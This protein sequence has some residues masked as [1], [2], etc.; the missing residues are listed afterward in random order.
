MSKYIFT[1]NPVSTLAAGVNNTDTSLFLQTGEGSLFALPTGD[2]IQA[3]TLTDNAGN[4]E[5]CHVTGRATD[6]L[7]VIRG[8][9]GTAALPWL[10]GDSVSGRNTAGALN[11]TVQNDGSQDLKT[12][13]N[14]DLVDG[15]EPSNASGGISINNTILNADLNADQIDDLEGEELMLKA[16]N[17][18]DVDDLGAAKQNLGIGKHPWW[19]QFL[20]DGSDGAVIHAVNTSLPK[21]EYHFTDYTLNSGVI[22]DTT[23]VSDSFLI[24]RC[25][26]T[27]TIIGSI[28]MSG[29]GPEGAISVLN[30]VGASGYSGFLGGGGG[31]GGRDDSLNAGDGGRTSFKGY[32]VNGGA[33]RSGS[34]GPGSDGS[35]VTNAQLK[36]FMEYYGLDAF[37]RGGG[38]GG[39]G[40]SSDGLSADGGNGGPVV[41]IIADTIDFRTGATIDCS[42]EDGEDGGSLAAAGGGGGGGSVFLF[43]RVITNDGVIDVTG[44]AGGAG[45]IGYDGGDGG[46]GFS[47]VKTVT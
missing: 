16:N 9:E 8:R 12:D 42:G 30:Q 22:L 27:A 29:R 13:L 32:I 25:N 7:T 39:A 28:N 15:Y 34:N 10:S 14:S 3:V 46:D 41:I 47:I 21:G 17:L 2:E 24:I 33:G 38:G 11:Q 1:N 20:G 37:Y 31:G 26:G 18:S 43:G 45:V 6:T 36:E 23:E 19:H 44:G 35:S 4:I 40:T 5:I